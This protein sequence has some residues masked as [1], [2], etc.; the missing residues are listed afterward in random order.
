M[1]EGVRAATE[2][3]LE[4]IVALTAAKRRRLAAWSPTWW[5]PAEGADE[6]HRA[7]LGYL[8]RGDG[9]IVRVL[10]DDGVV[11]GCVVSVP[12][13]RQWFVD[14]VALAEDEPET[15]WGVELLRS[16]PERPA[17]TCIPTLDLDGQVT[18]QQA[19][20]EHASSYWIR[21]TEPAAV[22]DVGR[23]R[24]SAAQGPRHTFGGPFDPTDR[25]TLAIATAGGV[26]TGSPP[27]APPPVYGT[28]GTVTIVDRA[29][30]PDRP[31]LLRA[32]LAVAHGRGDVLV[33]VV[34]AADDG[35]LEEA[36]T[37]CGF[38]RTVEVYAWP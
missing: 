18:A 12:Q 35:D 23:V 13:G 4:A 7:W 34:C 21:A 33:C 36:L 26:V 25:T 9:P 19:G 30:G 3:D 6:L 38:D 15:P 16:I 17:L 20:L 1:S 22:V 24:P 11:V 2:G 29:I 5:H 27:I 32:A 28:G 8:V 31:A 37:G 14:D 10:V